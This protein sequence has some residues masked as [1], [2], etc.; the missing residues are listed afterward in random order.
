M[1]TPPLFFGR[2]LRARLPP[3]HKFT[4]LLQILLPALPYSDIE[5]NVAGVLIGGDFSR[6]RH[7]GRSIRAAFTFVRQ[8]AP[9][10]LSLGQGHGVPPYA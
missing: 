1:W 10:L 7:P 4:S 8:P 6:L 2:R 3:F 5:Y 9:S